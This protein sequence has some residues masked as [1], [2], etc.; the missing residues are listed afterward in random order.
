MLLDH[1]GRGKYNK[2]KKQ[3]SKGHAHCAAVY[4]EA[5]LS[6]GFLRFMGV[7]G[8]TNL[9]QARDMRAARLLTL[10]IAHIDTRMLTLTISHAQPVDS[11]IGR[12]YKRRVGEKYLAWLASDDAVPYFSTGKGTI[13]APARRA[14]MTKWVGEVYDELEAERAALAAAGNEE[15]SRF[16]KAFQRTGML[17]R[18][19]GTND[20][21]ICPEW[22]GPEFHKT[23][24]SAQQ[25][26]RDV[27]TEK[28]LEKWKF[29][30]STTDSSASDSGEENLRADSSC[31]ENSEDIECTGPFMPTDE[32]RALMRAVQAQVQTEA[33]DRAF[34]VRVQG[35]F[36]GVHQGH[37]IEENRGNGKRKRK[38]LHENLNT[39]GLM[40]R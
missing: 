15:Q 12:E 23:L 25:V 16:F 35:E 3:R 20:A 36:D 27:E 19:S 26:K 37:N 9:W 6:A 29:D 2:K 8:A 11:G 10:A 4:K 21:L 22:L 32:E 1:L 28:D 40:F 33:A 5:L 31:A 39:D 38:V 30:I 7:P 24:M 13:G 14:L 18:P 17:V 34:A